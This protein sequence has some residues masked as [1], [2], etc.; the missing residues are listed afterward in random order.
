[1]TPWADINCSVTSTGFWCSAAGQSGIAPYTYSDWQYW[2]PAGSWSGSGSSLSG[3]FGFPGCNSGQLNS[4]L[5]RLTDS[6]GRST[7]TG[8]E[9]YCPDSG[10]GF[11]D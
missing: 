1:M 9:F 11:G 10:P 3:S 6:Y 5:V 7:F 2:G 4:V 8:A